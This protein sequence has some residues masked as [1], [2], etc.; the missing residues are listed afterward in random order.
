LCGF[1]D[2]GIEMVLF[3]LQYRCWFTCAWRGCSWCSLVDKECYLWSTLLHVFGSIY[4]VFG[5]PFL[6]QSTIQ[7]Q[8]WLVELHLLIE[9]TLANFN[10]TFI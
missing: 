2:T 3:G 1:V 8:R 7:W 4:W 6:W 9:V 10:M 5:I